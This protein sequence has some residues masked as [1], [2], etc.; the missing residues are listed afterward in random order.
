MSTVFVVNGEVTR[1]QVLATFPCELDKK[2]SEAGIT[3]ATADGFWVLGE[4]SSAWLCFSGDLLTAFTTY[5]SS[6]F[7][8]DLTAIYDVQVVSEHDEDFDEAAED[9]PNIMRFKG[10]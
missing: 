10:E 8:E 1:Q 6:R 9:N 4:G 3:L 5:G 7:D 2:Q